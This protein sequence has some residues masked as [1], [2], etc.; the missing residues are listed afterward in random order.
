MSSSRKVKTTTRD[1]TAS[2]NVD[3]SIK[4]REVSRNIVAEEDL[5]SVS[6][7][8]ATPVK[9]INPSFVVERYMHTFCNHATQ[10]YTFW[11]ERLHLYCL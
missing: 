10:Y 5:I 8:V 2:G 9:G 11:Q 3:E 4:E 7:T 1:L 6:S